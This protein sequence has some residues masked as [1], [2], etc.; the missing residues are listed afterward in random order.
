MAVDP[1]LPAVFTRAEAL[2]AGLSRHQIAQRVRSGRWLALRRSV[3]A[4]EP[5]YA[6]LPVRE[7]H[8]LSVVA[9]LLTRGED[10]VASHLSAAVAYGWVLPLDGPGPA[11]LTC[12]DLGL[13]TRRGT[14]HVVQV[15]TLPESDRAHLWTSAAGGRWDIRVTSRARTVADNLRHLRLPDGVALGDSAL[16]EGRVT[17]DQVA[18]VLER[19]ASWPYIERGRKAL[20][21]LDPRRETW[22]ESYSFA[23]LHLLGLPLPEPQVTIVNARGL[24]VARVDGWID[25]S[26]VALEPDGHEKYF[27]RSAP[28]PED[29]DLAADELAARARKAVIEEKTREDRLRDLGVQVV[30]WGTSDIVRRPR[31]VMARVASAR[32][33][34]DRARFAGRTAYLSRPSWLEPPRRRT[35]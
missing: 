4:D 30:R 23:R 10:V 15:A 31:D 33:R 16:R 18:S 6:A 26:A 24:F 22:L 7:Q 19:Q 5:R 20:P 21:L 9:A 32:A 14:E 28:L 2:A 1:E 25:E 8:L 11:T 12:G 13:P 29:A 34:G 35:G 27:L 17:F 3:Y